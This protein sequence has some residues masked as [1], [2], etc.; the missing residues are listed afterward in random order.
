M[1]WRVRGEIPLS[2]TSHEIRGH[3]CF[4]QVVRADGNSE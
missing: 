1:A 4:G 3:I 2:S